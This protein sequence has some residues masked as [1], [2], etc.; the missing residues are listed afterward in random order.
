[1]LTLIITGTELFDEENQEFLTVDETTIELEHSLLSVSKWEAKFQKPFL[2]NGEKTTEEI[3]HYIKMMVLTPGFSDELFS[4]FSEQNFKEINDY[5]DSNESATTFS[6]LP[7]TGG[8]S[9]IVTSELIYYWLV[10]FR[11]PFECQTWH[12][13]RLFS[14]IRICNLKNTKPKKMSKRE[15]AE[16]NR[17][18]NAR[19][20]A[21]LGT[22]G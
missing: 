16:R 14:L 22:S 15:I 9:E 13:S 2:T 12:L 17:D 21:A 18:L 20:K 11:I 10:T 6:D 7:K 1:M 19:R 4:K 8:R 3:L 5:I